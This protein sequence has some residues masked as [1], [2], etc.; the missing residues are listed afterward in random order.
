MA[1][2]L[3]TV[4]LNNTRILEVDAVPGVALGTAAPIGSLA[5]FTTGA[6]ASVYYKFGSLDTQWKEFNKAGDVSFDNTTNG[7]TATQ[8]QAAIEEAKNWTRSGTTLYPKVNADK[9]RIGDQAAATRFLD[10]RG[11]MILV[12][13]T[14]NTSSPTIVQNTINDGNYLFLRNELGTDIVQF[15]S[16]T[17][18]HS[19]VKF[20]M[21][22]GQKTFV[23]DSGS[24]KIG[25][26]TNE[27]DSAWPLLVQGTSGAGGGNGQKIIAGE[28]AGDIGLRVAD[29]DQ[30]LTVVEVET[31]SGRTVF[32]RT[33][34]STLA[35]FGVVY[36]IDHQGNNGGSY[37]DMN[38]QYGVYRHAGNACFH[39]SFFQNAISDG[40][41]TTTSTTP[42]TKLTLT[43]PSLPSGNYRLGW[44]Y[45]WGGSDVAQDVEV[46]VLDGAT[47]L[48]RT[49]LAP[50]ATDAYA[51]VGG[52][53]YLNAI[54]GV[55]TITIK[56]DSEVGTATAK[57]RRAR[58]EFWRMS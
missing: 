35:E 39:G 28:V 11:D 29:Q 12:Y 38:V 31:G 2:I 24:V 44:Y 4:T 16:N 26:G 49:E 53:Y 20:F 56:Y 48:S 13:N 1:N 52:F 6:V 22:D 47:V 36:G 25:R 5:I 17:N 10:I 27:V 3:G 15:R 45:E 42:Q 32:Q 19:V 7:F 57:I 55:R 54:S 43:T 51:G 21:N 18:S 23:S 9:V 58:L 50:E 46:E 34:A 14:P 8:A 33:Y 41:S 30:S 37:N 40:E